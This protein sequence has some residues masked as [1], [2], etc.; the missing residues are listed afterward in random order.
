MTQ[1]A[2]TI[3]MVSYSDCIVVRSNANIQEG[4]W[5]VF[6]PFTPDCQIR[7]VVAIN[8]NN[9]TLNIAPALIAVPTET[10]KVLVQEK[11]E[12]NIALFG[13]SPQNE[14]IVNTKAIQAAIAD[15]NLNGGGIVSFPKGVFEVC[16]TANDKACFHISTNSVLQFMGESKEETV[17][18]MADT[19]ETA[20]FYVTSTHCK[21]QWQ[22]M[23]LTTTKGFAIH[24][25][26]EDKKDEQHPCSLVIDEVAFINANH[27]AICVNQ[28]IQN[29]T[30][31][32]CIM[33]GFEN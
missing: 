4:N 21:L 14:A 17:L 9:N 28:T 27:Q 12:W 30:I 31:T 32:N 26:L 16:A 25:E 23:C 33:K 13:A 10:I 24:C 7:K 2:E 18:Q 5:I 1:I 3:T 19:K 15:C 11:P 6:N 20:L 22:K 8:N 29:L